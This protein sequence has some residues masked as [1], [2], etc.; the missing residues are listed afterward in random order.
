MLGGNAHGGADAGGFY[1]GLG[2]ASSYLYQVIGGRVC[3]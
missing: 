3:Y 1:W 2:S